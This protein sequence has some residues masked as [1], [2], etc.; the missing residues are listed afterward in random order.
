MVLKALLAKQERKVL[1]V[2]EVLPVRKVRKDFQEV[3]SVM[4]IFML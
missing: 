4:Q 1:R 2:R 3:C